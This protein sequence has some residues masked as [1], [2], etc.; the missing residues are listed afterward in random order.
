MGV[1][2]GIG[3]RWGRLALGLGMAW[4]AVGC[5]DHRRCDEPAAA[6]QGA[7]PDLLSRAGLY[8]DIEGEV[9]AEDT[10]AYTP[11]Y[12]L[13]TDG[14]DKRRWLQLPA[15]T[16]IN[17]QDPDAWDF[18]VGARLWKEFSR[19][20]LRIETRLLQRVGAGEGDW[21]M[22]AYLWDADQGE[23]RAQPEGVEDAAGTAHD[24]PAAADCQG[25]HAGTAARVLGVS[26]V[27]LP[28][29]ADP[30]EVDAAGLWARGQLTTDPGPPVVVPGA[31]GADTTIPDGLG[32]LHANCAHCHNADRPAPT[33]A[34]CWDPELP[35][36]FSLRTDALGRVEDTATFQTAVGLVLLP[37]DPA[38]SYALELMRERGR[39]LG[40]EK[41]MP[42]LGTEEVDPAGVDRVER[43]ILAL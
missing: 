16:A 22:M 1:A 31:D 41:G 6:L 15:G 37:G 19:D 17:N 26:A 42:P 28:A 11:R 34:R 7:L 3:G 5:M 33:G 12:G 9:L 40:Y 25:C 8:T 24:V 18:P 27:Q 29:E 20:G 23:A 14:A 35:F 39:V 36:D 13:W 21:A 2:A 30:G 32:Y 38:H 10:L 43:L 4:G